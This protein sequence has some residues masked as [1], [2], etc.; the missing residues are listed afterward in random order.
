MQPKIPKLKSR[1]IPVYSAQYS[2]TNNLQWWKETDSYYYPNVLLNLMTINEK[3]IKRLEFPKNMFLLTDSGGFQ[4]ISG[5]CNIDWKQSIDIQVKLGATKIF[6]F[7]KPPV[8]RKTEGVN[9]FTYMSNE[10]TKK[11]IEENL[12]VAI[13]QSKYLQEKYPEFRDRFCYIL[14]GR[15]KQHWDYNLQLIKEKLGGSEGYDEYFPGG[16]TYA[17]KSNDILILAIAAAHAKK[18]FISRRR[19]VHF[20]GCGSFNKMFI[21][22]RNQITTFDS[23]TALQ[24][25]KV[26]SYINP[27]NIF[28]NIMIPTD[29]IPFETQFCS[30]PICSN[31][32]YHQLTKDNSTLVGRNFVIHNLWHMLKMNIFLDSLKID[33]YTKIIKEQFKPNDKTLQA[34]EFI[35]YSDKNGFEIAYEKY[36]HFLGKDETKQKGLF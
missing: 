10:E 35:D 34:L 23:S 21:L 17:I 9:D 19:Y 26:N 14:H 2:F 33:V 16:I 32:D 15:N 3:V 28:K 8:K 31:M 5:Q 27:C 13:K 18:Y 36:K 24:G 12:N 22:V 29:N 11:Q 7:D 25:S 30:C 4:V 1:Y 6:A 20:L